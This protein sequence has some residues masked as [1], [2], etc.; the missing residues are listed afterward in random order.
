MKS[1][2]PQPVLNLSVGRGTLDRKF[3][4]GKG[5]ENLW[6]ISIRFHRIILRS[7]NGGQVC[8]TESP[9][10]KVPPL[11]L[12]CP[13]AQFMPTIG[14]G[15]NRPSNFGHDIGHM[16]KPSGRCR[17]QGRLV[18]QAGRQTRSGRRRTSGVKHINDLTAQG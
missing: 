9:Y 4:C 2:D 15:R 5:C 14:T 8:H 3:N 11:R 12:M 7:S 18:D 10:S 1:D 13:S 16:N 17:G 6:M